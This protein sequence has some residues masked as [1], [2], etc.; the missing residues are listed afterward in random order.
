MVRR[1]LLARAMVLRPRAVFATLLA[2]AMVA[3]AWRRRVLAGCGWARATASVPVQQME[4]TLRLMVTTK[5]LATVTGTTSASRFGCIN[6]GSAATDQD[7][8]KA[9][10]ISQY[11]Q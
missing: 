7:R 11:M 9:P 1:V 8:M 5:V 6:S 10:T 2:L 3:A 4:T